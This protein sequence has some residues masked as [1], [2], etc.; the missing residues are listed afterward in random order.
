MPVDYLTPSYDRR[1]V[2]TGQAA[3]FMKQADEEEYA[4]LPPDTLALGTVWPVADNWD[5]IGATQDGLQFG[6]QRT[7]QDIHI[8]EQ[9]N[10][11]D[12]RTK[13]LKFQMQLDFS[14]D[15][16]KT[17]RIAYGGGNITTAVATA[18]AWGYSELIISDEMEDFAFGFEGQN[19]FQAPRRAVVPIVKSVGNIK[20]MYRRAAR[21][22]I[23]SVNLESL[24]PLA[25][26]PIRDLTAPPTGP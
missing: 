2:L 12:T 21:Q 26:C 13:D 9:P 16:L 4:T 18:T 8:E 11:V 22:R 17:M 14:E 5:P 25:V 23:Y 6:F 15:T 19:Q 24:V 7:K 20:T 1:N 10:P 3:C